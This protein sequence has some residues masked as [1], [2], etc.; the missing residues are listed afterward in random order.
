MCAGD[1]GMPVPSDM[2]ANPREIFDRANVT[3]S[4]G[5]LRNE[6]HG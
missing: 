6:A 4:G 2:D 3:L 1:Q 5:A